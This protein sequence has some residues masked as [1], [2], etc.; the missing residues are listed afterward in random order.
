MRLLRELANSATS[1]GG[2]CMP[3]ARLLDIVKLNQSFFGLGPRCESNIYQHLE[4]FIAA[5][6]ADDE[7]VV[8]TLPHRYDLDSDHPVHDEPVLV[9]AYIEEL[10]GR[11]NARV[12]NLGR[13]CTKVLPEGQVASS[14]DDFKRC[15]DESSQ[16][17]LSH[18]SN[19]AATTSPAIY[20]DPAATPPHT[21]TPKDCS[22]FSTDKSGSATAVP[23]GVN[24]GQAASMSPEVESLASATEASEHTHRQFYDRPTRPF[25]CECLSVVS[26]NVALMC[27]K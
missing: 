18:M 24:V 7:F 10:A 19:P 15:I 11:Y 25:R 9:N 13:G 26:L 21:N 5:R 17:S 4:G 27:D 3:G 20:Q 23:L 22:T 6:Q 16:D 1:V 14:M 12:L 2:V 8:A